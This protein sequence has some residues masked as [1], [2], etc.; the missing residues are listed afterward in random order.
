MA[1]NFNPIPLDQCFDNIGTNRNTT[2]IFDLT[3]GDGL[4]VSN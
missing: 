4:A 2:Y 3:S 1:D